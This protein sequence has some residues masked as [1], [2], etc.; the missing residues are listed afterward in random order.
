MI[1][2]RKAIA[3]DHEQIWQILKAI[4]LKGDVLAF[5]PD[6]T[7]EEMLHYW[8]NPS[9]HTYIALRENEIVGT[10]FIQ[11]NQP[12]LG[13]HV[14][15]AGYA[16]SP[17]HAGIGAGRAMA[18]WSLE[19]ARRLGYTAMQYNIVVKSNT[20]AVNLWKKI[21]FEIIGEIP[22]AF[23]HQTNGMTN[24]YIMYRAL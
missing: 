14:A 24:A 9:K 16:V 1:S 7:Q 6:S 12:G 23:N 20:V 18:E 22:N 19:E 10:F 3:A 17:D 21:G 2:I 4:I 11:N 13:D 8:C 5:A 15:N